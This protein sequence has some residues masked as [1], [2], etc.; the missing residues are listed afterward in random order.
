MYGCCMAL[1]H[2]KHTGLRNNYVNINSLVLLFKF[3][4]EK[5]LQ[6]QSTCAKK[7]EGIINYI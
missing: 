5:K 4:G 3:T 2:S 1:K 7:L 6:V